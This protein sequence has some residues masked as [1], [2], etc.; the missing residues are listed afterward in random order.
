[1][2]TNEPLPPLNVPARLIPVPSSISPE[3]QSML[4]MGTITSPEFPPVEDHE[5]W[6]KF[7]TESDELVASYLTSRIPA[8]VVVMQME[9]EGVGVFSITPPDVDPVDPRIY[10]DIHGGG[11]TMGGGDCGRAMSTL[12][13][14]SVGMHVWAVDYRMPPDDPYPASLDDCLVVYRELLREHGPDEVIVGGGSAGGNL[15]AALILRARDEGLP[16]PAAAVLLS[17][18][19]DLTESGDSFQANLG[20]D[21]VLTRSLMPANLLYAGGHDLSDPYVSPLFGDFSQGFPPTL[22]GSGTRDL[23]LSNAVRLHRALRSA[24]ISADLHVLEAAPHGGFMAETEEDQ[25][26]DA[27]VR[28]FIE[29]HCPRK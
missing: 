11:L 3:A 7:R 27:E 16:L 23:F 26:L 19:V 13:A 20:V 8:G 17:P 4:A 10:L 22:I 25:A 29:E 24:G 28:Y 18:E 9:V 21:T 2:S 5:A 14:L 1:M 15:A 6:R 12:T